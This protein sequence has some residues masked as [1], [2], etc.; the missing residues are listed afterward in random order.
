ME[1]SRSK[2]G[3]RTMRKLVLITILILLA[4]GVPGASGTMLSIGGPVLKSGDVSS[5][6]SGCVHWV[7]STTWEIVGHAY[8]YGYVQGVGYNTPLHFRA[9][10]TAKVVTPLLT[11][12]W[13]ASGYGYGSCY[14]SSSRNAGGSGAIGWV[15]SKGIT[16]LGP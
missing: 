9:Y 16:V 2:V 12:I 14:F 1:R 15:I 8:A 3:I 11:T 7:G 5:G 6:V 10:V 13:T 4:I